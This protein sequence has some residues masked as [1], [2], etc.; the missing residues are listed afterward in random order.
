MLY[1]DVMIIGSGLK[2]D[3]KIWLICVIL[4]SVNIKLNDLD[5]QE[6]CKEINLK[7]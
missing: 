4:I 5:K 6:N 7:L 1:G 2:D 3:L